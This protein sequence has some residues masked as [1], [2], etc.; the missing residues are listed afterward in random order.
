MLQSWALMRETPSQR[1]IWGTFPDPPPTDWRSP[2]AALEECGHS[3]D[4]GVAGD[5]RVGAR[6]SSCQHWPPPSLNRVATKRSLHPF[7][8]ALQKNC[9]VRNIWEP[10]S[11]EVLLY[12]TRVPGLYCNSGTPLNGRPW[13][14]GGGGIAW[15]IALS[16]FVWGYSMT[17]RTKGTPLSICISRAVIDC[18]I[19]Q[20]G[21]GCSQGHVIVMWL[22][23]PSC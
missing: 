22:N 16:L 14:R 11:K 20:E 12:R 13:I 15:H 4:G 3:Q 1:R 18:D 23:P 9:H 19:W 17:H 7:I 5:S 21:S 6:S 8:L 2:T 10:F